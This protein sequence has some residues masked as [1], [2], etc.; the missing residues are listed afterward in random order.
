MSPTDLARAPGAFA[1]FHAALNEGRFV[2]QQ[3]QSTGQFVFPPRVA[4]PG[5]GADD[6]EWREV[7]GRGTIHALTIIARKPERGG[8][9][10]IA[11][12][13]LEEGPR[14]MSRVV[15]VDPASLRIGMAVSA[16][17]ERPDFGTLKDKG[18]ALVL[19]RPALEGHSR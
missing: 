19:F 2:L 11:I 14:M 10:N 13:E 6:L 4:A 18:Q 16:S 8:D 7:S 15:G 17:V 5:T 12:I 1:C 9:Y 3:S